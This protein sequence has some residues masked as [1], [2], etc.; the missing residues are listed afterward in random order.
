MSIL[1]AYDPARAAVLEPSHAASPVESFPE[2]VVVTFQP[3][4]TQA[5]AGWP[6]SRVLGHLPVFFQI[7]I[8]AIHYE[9]KTF[10]LYQ[11]LLGS[12]ASAAMMEEVI[13]R[14]AR[15]FVLFG[16]CG[17]LTGDLPAGHLIVPTAARRDEGVSYHY[18]PPEDDYLPLDTAPRT[19]QVLS[20]LGTPF[21]E[22]RTWTTDA[23]YR[24][25]RRNVGRRQAE[26]C[27][28]VDMECAACAAVCKFRGVEFYQFLYT[29][30]SLAGDLW[31]P[32][33]LGKLPQDAK[34]AYFRLALELA[35]RVTP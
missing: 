31:D 34:D 9:D 18:L 10:G 33:L 8:Y 16:S 22:G 26:G 13:A 20:A 3:S 2:T 5:A 35:R 27:L 30:D 24:E 28:C 17:S 11:T 23:L 7:P 21:V 25:T 6:G 14:G 19:A 12:A 15:R 1:D 4:L 29:E 32:G